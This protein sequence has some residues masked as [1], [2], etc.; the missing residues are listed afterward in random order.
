M[1]MQFFR[2][3]IVALTAQGLEINTSNNKFVEKA[4]G[5][6]VKLGCFFTTGPKDEGMLEIEWTVKSI[7]HPM[8]RATVLWYTAEHIYDNLYEHLKGRV[9][10]DAQD[11][12][13]GDAAIHLLQLTR[14]DTGIYYCQ[15]KKLPGIQSIKTVLRVLERPSKPKCNYTQGGGE[16]GKTKVLHCGSEEGAPPIRYHWSRLP[17]WELLSSLAV[18]DQRA[19]TLTIPDFSESDTGSYKCVAINR[20][21]QEK[22]ILKVNIPHPP[23]VGIIAGSA[24]AAVA[25]I[26]II[27]YLTYSIIRRRQPKLENSNE[28]VEDA[29]P[30]TPRKIMKT[31]RRKSDKALVT[32]KRGCST[33]NTVIAGG[34]KG[35]V[36]EK[37][38]MRGAWCRVHGLSAC[39][40]MMSDNNK[41]NNAA[42][43]WK[44][45]CP[46]LG[47]KPANPPDSP[48]PEMPETGVESPSSG[49]V[50]D[51][52]QRST[53][54]LP[55]STGEHFLCQQQ[56]VHYSGKDELGSNTNSGSSL[57]LLK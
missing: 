42:V 27:A 14:K 22:C 51:G 38:L 49:K 56:V 2:L 43:S 28:I 37:K 9:Y 30:P 16:F 36:R 17:P 31:K 46:G 25:T 34:V 41:L 23:S 5:E 48:V 3:V 32:M 18:L 52:K 33:D 55:E 50:A 1:G 10:F 57:V 4:V 40:F 20:V 15:V 21:G 19:G 11:P 12:Q 44:E 24:A 53:R 47:G 26:G 6:D 29:S 7:R 35:A 39:P 45:P 54:S 13:Q 8:E